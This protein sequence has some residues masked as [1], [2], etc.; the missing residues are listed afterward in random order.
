M[1]TKSQ[2][3]FVKNKSDNINIVSFFS[4]VFTLVDKANTVDIINLDFNK[5]SDK[6][7]QAFSLTN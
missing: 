2:Y 3:G 6:V 5:G 7:P 1:V 4:L